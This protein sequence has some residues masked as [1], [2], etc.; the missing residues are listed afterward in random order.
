MAVDEIVGFWPEKISN[1]S[2]LNHKMEMGMEVRMRMV[3]VRWRM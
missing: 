1:G 3:I 2:Q